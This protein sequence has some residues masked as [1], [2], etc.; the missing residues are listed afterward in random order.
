MMYKKI[1]LT[2][3]ALISSA[4]FASGVNSKISSDTDYKASES[5]QEESTVPIASFKSN[6]LIVKLK[7]EPVALY[8]SRTSKTKSVSR[9]VLNYK[10]AKSL[11]YINKLKTEQ[12]SVM[13]RVNKTLPKSQVSSYVNEKGQRFE[14]RYTK[15]FNGF[16]INIGDSDI[17]DAIREIKNIPGVA[18]VYKDRI[19]Q[20]T[21]YSSLELINAEALWNNPGINGFENAGA[22]I[23]VASMDG[24]VH[25]NSPMF[26]GEGFTYPEGFG[27]NG[28]GDIT[29]NNGKIIVSRAYFRTDD[30]PVAGDEN[31][32][33]GENGTSH[34][35]HTS[36]TMVGN[37]VEADY[38]GYTEDSDGNPLKISGVAPKAWIMSYRIGYPSVSG[39]EGFYTAEGIAALED[40][41]TDG[42]DILNNSWATGPVSP[43]GESNPIDMA[44]INAAEAGIFISMAA[45]NSGPGP[46]TVDHPSDDY[47]CVASTSTG[48]TF[49]SSDS[50]DVENSEDISDIEFG[51]AEFGNRIESGQLNRYDVVAAANLITANTDGCDEWPTDTDFAGKAVLISRGDCTF[52]EKVFNAQER[53]AGLVII[54]NHANGGDSI[55]SMPA[56]A[57]AELVTIPSLFVGHTNG[58]ALID[59][60]TD[61][62]DEQITINTVAFQAGNT[63]DRVADF[64]S[65]GPAV[66]NVLKPDI[67]APGVNI[68]SQGYTEGAT[69]EARHFGYDQA[70]GTS[71]ASPHVAGA[72]A[73]IRQVYP[74]WSNAYIKS[75]LM[76]TSQYKNIFNHDGTPA[77][78]LD[79]GAGR[80][81]LAHVTDPGVILDPPSLSFGLMSLN[82]KKSIIVKVTNITNSKEEY[83]IASEFTADG[84][85]GT[86]PPVA[87]I[88]IFPES[89]TI[90]AGATA[91]LTIT[92]VANL[93]NGI[94]DNQGYITLSGNNHNA[95]M[96]AWARVK[97][98]T[99]SDILL[100]DNDCSDIL[101]GDDFPD[102]REYYTDAFDELGLSYDVWNA[103]Q[104]S[105]SAST[106]PETAKL[107]AY[108]TI[109]YF[110]GN[111]YYSDGSFPESTPLTTTDMDRLTDYVNSGG[112]IIVMGQDVADITGYRANINGDLPFFYA[113]ILG[114]EMLQNSISEGVLPLKPITAS[115]N[116]PV[117]FADITLDFSARPEGNDDPNYGAQN[118]YYID[119]LSDK[120]NFDLSYMNLQSMPYVSILKYDSETLIENG[121]VAMLHRDNISFDNPYSAFDGRSIYTAFGLEGINNLSGTTSRAELMKILIDCL[122]D[123]P[124]ASIIQNSDTK[125]AVTFQASMT[126][127]VEDA[128]AVSYKWDFGDGTDYVTTETDS[129]D[130]TY[131]AVGSYVA[132]VEITDSFGNIS[133]AS[134]SLD[135]EPDLK[136]GGGLCFINALF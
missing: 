128:V 22:G 79:I 125:D 96:P 1:L 122:N 17:D 95:H 98:V 6:R 104:F 62:P 36:G 71:M 2:A 129:V 25:H 46:G 58:L 83:T 55:Q 75:A 42:A 14:N 11:T 32:W 34:G 123:E 63:A 48:G 39:A 93:G 51:T 86:L 19:Y 105:G 89:L 67:A 102:Y 132:R 99:D 37:S 76:T 43:G 78:P 133:I 101:G 10:S 97:A 53:N 110:S 44:L 69:G 4:V 61:N 91:E 24:G 40:I 35:V 88:T 94:G 112:H 135:G 85:D 65:R 52:S 109:V 3:V 73:L 66:G 26:S 130:H 134:M 38:L 29:N 87:G 9:R 15:L 136:K 41:V 74:E 68:L 120:P 31:V 82:E 20:P 106:I 13:S 8:H 30:G 77:Q 117:A 111:N 107:L 27:E 100:I 21:M 56:G 45:G 5:F 92:Y 16:A 57:S 119:E 28:L 103:E 60:F 59:Y 47:I 33:P 7:S 64:S 23:K 113:N 126:S 49:A 50:I 121:V 118:Q 115:H 80:L 124:V 90:A 116:S 70:S 18:G 81:D 54:Y 72:A 12:N 114:G 108:K 127:N 131:S 84:F